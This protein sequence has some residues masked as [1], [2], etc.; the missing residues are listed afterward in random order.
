GADYVLSLDE[1]NLEIVK[2]TACVPILV[3][4]PHGDLASLV[5]AFDKATAL[6]IRA[7]AD[8]ILDPIHFGLTASLQ[9]YAELR[10]QRP[11]A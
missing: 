5:R 7:I 9:R 8:P 1:T 4:K 6:G 2:G 10:R 3:A 11:D